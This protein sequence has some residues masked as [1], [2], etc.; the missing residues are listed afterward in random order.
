[1]PELEIHSINVS[2]GDSTLII[3]RDINKLEQNIDKAI[4]AKKTL[5]PKPTNPVDFLPF[6][7]SQNIDLKSTIRT[8]MLIDAGDDIYGGDVANYLEQQGVDNTTAFYT[9]ATHYHADHVGGFYAVFYKNFD[10]K[11]KLDLQTVNLVPIVAYDCGDLLKWDNTLTKTI[12]KAYIA[13]L[14]RRG[15]TKTDVFKFSK[16]HKLGQ[17]SK[18]VCIYLKAVASNGTVSV[19]GQNNEKQVIDPKKSPD[20]NARSVTLILKYGDFRCFLGGDIGG[21]GEESGGNFG[22]NKDTRVKAF[23]SS[24]PDI[25]T[26]ITKVLPKVIKEDSTRARTAPGH[27]CLHSANHHGSASSNDVFLIE[28]MQ[29]KVVF[30]SAGIKASFHCHPTQEFFQRMDKNAMYSPSWQAPGNTTTS[31]P[32]IPNTV[33]GYYITEMAQDGRYGKGKAAKRY[34]RMLPHGKILGDII[35]RPISQVNPNH[36]LFSGS[37]DIQVYG[38]GIT[39]DSTMSPIPLRPMEPATQA[40]LYP[41]GPFIHSCDKH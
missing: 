5:G 18:G 27:I 20:Q 39:T 40:P 37:I 29:P 33:D 13:D 38:T 22:A 34:N 11:K 31:N 9:L 15:F 21:T 32:T 8:A 12:Y 24:H 10:V 14:M 41:I 25:E 19:D 23:Y 2:Q 16:N 36:M 17:D 35:M 28:Q 4:K 3:N 1:M 30:C 7:V 26:H 6:A